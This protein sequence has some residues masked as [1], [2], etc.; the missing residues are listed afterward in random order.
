MQTYPLGWQSWSPPEPSLLKIPLWD[1]PPSPQLARNPKPRLKPAKPRISLW[2]SWHSNGTDINQNLLLNQ[3]HKFLTHR[4]VPEYIL[5]DDGWCPWGDWNNPFQPGW[6]QNLGVLTHQ[7]S[8]LGYKSG[9]WLAPFLVDQRSKL[10]QSHPEYLARDRSGQAINALMGYPL[11]RHL[12]PKYLLDL[13]NPQVTNYLQSVLTTIIKDWGFTLLKLDHLYAPYFHPDPAQGEKAS[14]ALPSLMSYINKQYPQ[15]YTIACGA[16][17]QDVLGHAD[18]IR[19]SKDI[20]S[21]QLRSFPLLNKLLYLKR[22]KLLSA[23]LELAWTLPEFNGHIDPDACLNPSDANHF[24][25][26]WQNDK[27]AVFGLGYNL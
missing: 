13:T 2:C 17:F 24:Y 26:L 5:I 14:R 8:Q 12:T 1:Y 18:A 3:A 25:T 19:L 9:L 16:P 10:F 20:N 21:P 22:K 6:S 15:V 7:L 11:L 4:Y 27:I 23:K